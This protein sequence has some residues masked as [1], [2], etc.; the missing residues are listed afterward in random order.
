MFW[1]QLHVHEKI[2]LF[3]KCLLHALSVLFGLSIVSIQLNIVRFNFLLVT[4]AIF[5]NR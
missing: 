4:G 3:Q 1:W 5:S 2:A